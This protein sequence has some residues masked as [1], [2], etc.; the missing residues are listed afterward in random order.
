MRSGPVGMT[1]VSP[2]ASGGARTVA[3]NRRGG[4]GGAKVSVAAAEVLDR[5]PPRLRV[6]RDGVG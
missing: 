3:G 4:L 5:N 6:E 2:A 1:P